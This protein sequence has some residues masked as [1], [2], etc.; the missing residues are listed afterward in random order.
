MRGQQVGTIPSKVK[1]RFYNI[2]VKTQMQL[3]QEAQRRIFDANRH[4]ME[5]INHETNPITKEDLHKLA[6]R[7][8]QRWKKYRT[9][10]D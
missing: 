6:D 7:F 9:L 4:V 10:L 3:C 8:P 1:F 5:M 2:M